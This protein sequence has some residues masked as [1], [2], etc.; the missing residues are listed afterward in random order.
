[1]A[2]A[3]LVV[4]IDSEGN[5]QAIKQARQEIAS[6]GKESNKTGD[7]LAGLKKAAAFAAGAFAAIKSAQ[8][9]VDFVKMGAQV[10][11]VEQRFVAFA[12]GAQQAQGYMEAFATATDGTVDRMGAMAGAS[13]MLQMGLVDN[14][15]EMETMAAIAVKLGNQTMGAS[16]RLGDFAALLA[17]RSIPRLDNFGISSGRVRERVQELTKA[18]HELDQAFKLAVLEEGRKSLEILGDTSELASTKIARIE[19]SLTDLKTG[20]AVA[21]VEVLDSTGILDRFAA[22]AGIIPETIERI[23]LVATSYAAG[24]GTFV[25]T[26]SK[27]EALAVFEGRLRAGAAAMVDMAAGEEQ[28][29]YGHVL[30]SG[31]L[32]ETTTRATAYNAE[33]AAI[34]EKYGSSTEAHA[35]YNAALQ[36]TYEG[37]DRAAIAAVE[38][39]EAQDRANE[40]AGTAAQ[41]FAGMAESLKGATEAQI[42]STA[43]RELSTLLEDGKIT[44]SDYAIAVQETQLAFGLADEASLNLSNR[45]NTLVENFGSGKVAA[46]EFDDGLAHLIDVNTMENLQIEKF[47]GLLA[48]QATPAMIVFTGE[49]DANS[50]S[51]E[52]AT[53]LTEAHRAKLREMEQQALA[54]TAQA[55]AFRDAIDSI[56]ATKDVTIRIREIKEIVRQESPGITIPE[57][58]RQ[59]GGPAAGLVLVHGPELVQLP[60]GSYVYS[61]QQTRAMLAG[62]GTQARPYGPVASGMGGGGRGGDLHLHVTIMPNAVRSDEDIEQIM[63]GTERILNLRGA[64][65]YRI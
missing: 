64:R 39:K 55:R 15:G 1:M 3:I 11:A 36:S 2:E 26:F 18:G 19:A 28:L 35:Q 42:A 65:E 7:S 43:I 47:G 53:G 41:K 44:A 10:Q 32:S 52:R 23:G 14:A 13:K 25:Q 56:P 45:L 6:T 58:S 60:Q 21:S 54:A 20:L 8:A 22:G 17:N 37:M 40:A 51:L 16:D 31:T 59:H 27:T 4:K 63:A 48:D 33:I 62:A 24:V 34:V 49:V 61:P 50:G 30:L 38:Y 9:A 12:G 46:T 29:R 57:I 5:V